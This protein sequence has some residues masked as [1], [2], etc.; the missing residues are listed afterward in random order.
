MSETGTRIGRYLVE[1]TLGRGAMGAVFRAHDPEIDRTVAIKLVHADL[2][3][4][5]ERTAFITR[6]RREAQAAAR[7]AH[8]N[9]VAVYDF[10]LHDGNPFLAMEFIDG[11]SLAG[12]RRQGER[13]DPADAGR[14]VLQVLAGLGAAH[15][16]GITHRDIKPANI[17]LARSGAVKVAD[18]GISRL[19]SSSLT[20]EGMLVGTPSYMSP[21]Q[22]R[23]EP[24]DGRSDLYS[25]GVV[26]Y[27]LLAGA[28][29]F[30]GATAGQLYVRLA[31]EDAPD[32]RS[33]RPD[34][35]PALAATVTRSL[36]RDRDARFPTADAMAAALRSASAEPA[37]DGTVALPS[38]MPLPADAGPFGR[39][40]VDTLE[41][42]LSEHVGPIARYL[43]QSA[44]RQAGDLDTLCAALAAKIEPGAERD[45]FAREVK[46]KLWATSGGPAGQSA[47]GSGLASGLTVPTAELARLQAELARHL[48][49][50]ARVLVKRALSNAGSLPALWQNLAQHIEREDDRAAFLRR[51]PGTTA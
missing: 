35:A 25:A 26:L 14:I 38:R 40:I 12:A 10:A 17:M 30:A 42:K 34:L 39:E 49:P 31:N 46:A 2:L 23:G 50:V 6:F 3:H 8:P 4:G 5:D 47:I 44:A 1:G 18:F 24:V 27:E 33:V 19:D 29:P 28:R 32:I 21:E 16:V 9:I 22:C 48:G 43:V 36:A 7:C 45:R 51:A 20:A 13:M 11:T 15:A 37:G 41:R